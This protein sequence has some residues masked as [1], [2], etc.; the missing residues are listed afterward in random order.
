MVKTIKK[1]IISQKSSSKRARG[2]KTKINSNKSKKKVKPSPRR[3]HPN[4]LDINYY[5]KTKIDFLLS[6]ERNTLI[7]LKQTENEEH[8]EIRREESPK[9]KPEY[10]AL[11]II[12]LKDIIYQVID[13]CQ[14]KL[15][16]DDNFIFSVISLYE[17]YIH[18]S[19]KDLSKNETIKSL[20]SCLILIDK[21]QK[22]GIFSVPFFQQSNPTFDLDLGILSVVD[23]NLFPVKLYDY[24]EV[25]FLRISQMKQDDKK[26]Q[27]YVK[28]FKEV[29][30]EFNFYFAF[31]ENA[32]IKKPSIN[33]I[34][35]L[36]M[37]YDF[38]KNN[39]F[40]E[41]DVIKG[42]INQFKDI[43]EYDEQQDYSFGKEIIIEA[44]NVYDKLVSGLKLNKKCKEGLISDV[45]IQCI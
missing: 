11:A 22:V 7:R 32:R 42:Y 19:E 23:L 15:K 29:F 1:P 14:N 2:A 27:D 21:F 30:L 17:R 8:L 12:G 43:M 10:R 6:E 18:N 20:F 4:P 35:C 3:I 28:R 33:F 31:H 38:I 37:T 25:F 9:Y 24:F 40:L 45:N 26:Y 5:V 13:S 41:N 34:S 16:L 39:F 44:K 36:K